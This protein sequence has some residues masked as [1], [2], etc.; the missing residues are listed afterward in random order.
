MKADRTPDTRLAEELPADAEPDF[1]AEHRDLTVGDLERGGPEHAPE[2]ESPNGYGGADFHRSRRPRKRSASVTAA[3]VLSV[4]A[5][6]TPFSPTSSPTR[7]G[8]PPPHRRQHR[9]VPHQ[10]RPLRLALPAAQTAPWVPD[11]VIKSRRVQ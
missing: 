7:P 10:P 2:P 6:P 3:S 5:S 8:T 9:R 11:G 1:A 4:P